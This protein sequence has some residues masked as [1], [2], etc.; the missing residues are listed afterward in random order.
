MENPNTRLFKYCPSCGKKELISGCPKSFIC[1][2]CGFKFY[3]NAAAAGI[4]LIFNPDMK[5]LVTR[6]KKDPHRNT[7]DF[8]G[9]FAEPFETMEETICREIKEELNL[10]VLDLT[11]FCSFPNI[12]VYK[13]ISYPITDMV[14]FCKVNDFTNICAMDDILDFSFQKISVLK[15]ESFG[16]ESPKRVLE[17]LKQIDLSNILMP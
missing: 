2:Q 1:N 4:G 15:P 6:R 13:T 7:L 12:Y 3:I 10:E 5:I 14:Y 11:Y 16:L 17:K 9:G 8:P